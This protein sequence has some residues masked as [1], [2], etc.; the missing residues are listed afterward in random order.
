MREFSVLMSVYHKENAD[1]FRLAL[2]SNME[3]SLPPKEFVL[4]CDG[5]LTDDLDAVI[6]EYCQLFPDVFR[7]VRLPENKGLGNALQVGVEHCSYDLVARSDSDDICVQDRFEKQVSFLEKHPEIS[8]VG[9]AIDEF[10]DDHTKPIR[11]K[12]LPLQPKD[13]LSF[14]K[15]RNPLNHM[16]VMFR[17]KDI[18]QSG[19]YKPLSYL[20]DYYLWLRVLGN[21][22]QIANISDRVG[23]ARVCK[24][25]QERRGSKKYRSGRK[26]LNCYMVSKKI[27]NRFG[28]FHNMLRIRTWCCMSGKMRALI[29]DNILRKRI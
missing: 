24:G 13:L 3:Q 10:D 8:V 27:I 18:L 26:T 23:Q 6:V 25:R 19:S 29:Y 7:V 2:N 1:H 22:Y 9:G 5:P 12:E 21:G 11:R 15:K 20:E 28:A 16:T 4:I 17:R 14:A